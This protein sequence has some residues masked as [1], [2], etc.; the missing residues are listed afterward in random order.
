[1]A[2]ERPGLPNLS[3]ELGG[4]SIGPEPEHVP[5]SQ[6]FRSLHFRV[7]S[8]RVPHPVFPLPP[9]FSSTPHRFGPD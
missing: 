1:M 8:C 6:H 9:H 2:L 5:P 7:Q 3:A 4:L